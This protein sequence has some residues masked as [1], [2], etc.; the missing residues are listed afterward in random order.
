MPKQLN[1]L[2]VNLAFTADTSQAKRQLQELQQQLTQLTNSSLGK[3]KDLGLVKDIQDATSAA[4]QLKVQLENATNVNTGKLDLG[5]FNDSLKQS[6]TTLADYKNQLDK[7]GPDGSKAFL[8]LAQSI[9]NAEMPL[10]RTN[11]LIKE[12]GVTLMNAARWQ[13]S[14]SVLHGLMGAMQGAYGYAQDLDKSLTNIAIVTGQ[15]RDEMAQFAEQANKSAQALSVSTTAY[16]DAALIYYQQGLDAAA[17]KA[18]TDITMMM[19]NVTG[20]SAE[21]VSSYMTAI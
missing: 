8:S 6:G 3:T 2:S 18:R 15:S 21:K 20:E 12:F 4:A 17:V 19:A 11:A 10:R 9:S 14:S 7:L 5:K 1:Q 13:F 16:T